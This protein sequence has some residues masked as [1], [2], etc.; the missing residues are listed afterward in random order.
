MKNQKKNKPV[1]KGAPVFLYTSLCC[2][3]LA[4]KAPCTSYGSVTT[5][6]P[7]SITTITLARGKEAETQGLGSW[8]CVT[9]R[10]PASVQR[11][12]NIQANKSA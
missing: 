4:E 1:Q 8:R 12:K 11:T 5:R 9:C 7:G 6:I 10:K 3:A 2:G